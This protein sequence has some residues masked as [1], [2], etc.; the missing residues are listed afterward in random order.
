MA[1]TVC[2]QNHPNSLWLLSNSVLAP[3]VHSPE[4]ARVVQSGACPAQ[5]PSGASTLGWSALACCPVLSQAGAQPFSHMAFFQFLRKGIRPFSTPEPLYLL[6]PLPRMLFTPYSLDRLLFIFGVSVQVVT[7][8]ESSFLTLILTDIP[9]C[10]FSY[11][12]KCPFK[13]ISPFAITYLQM[14]AETHICF[15]HQKTTQ[16]APYIIHLAYPEFSTVPGL[17]KRLSKFLW[18]KWMHKWRTWQLIEWRIKK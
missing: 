13:C 9:C 12:L 14:R 6:A 1:V 4:V 2:H 3:P 11:W 18:N 15:V 5:N 8:S 7:F 10:I 16:Y 17:W